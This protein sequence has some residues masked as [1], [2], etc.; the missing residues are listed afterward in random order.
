MLF[1]LIG[2]E[3]GPETRSKHAES[4]PETVHHLPP[5]VG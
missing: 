3:F 1:D 2:G 5:R 4:T